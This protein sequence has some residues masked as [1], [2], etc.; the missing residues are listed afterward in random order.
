MGIDL[1]GIGSA[2]KS[3][4][5]NIGAKAEDALDSAK[6]SVGEATNRVTDKV[7][8]GFSAVG[9]DRIAEG[10][11]DYGEGVSNRLG[12][13]VPERQLG[14]TDDPKELIHGSAPAIQARASH[15]ADFHKAFETVGQG[16]RGLDSGAWQ[17]NAG[18]AFRE[19]FGMQPP[20]C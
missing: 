5:D 7:A 12:G 15:L 4:V 17:G 11:R 18:D 8:D 20:A 10:V 1:P 2:I 9:A 19:K 3:G 6:E 16:L 14:E 13:D